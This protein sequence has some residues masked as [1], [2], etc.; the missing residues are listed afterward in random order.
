ML[1][2]PDA[3]FKMI[4]ADNCSYEVLIRERE[5]L[6]EEIRRLEGLIFEDTEKTDPA[7]KTIPSPDAAYPISLVYLEALSQ[8]MQK[9]YLE[10]KYESVGENK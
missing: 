2:D 9:R 4:D 3:Y 7:W 5:K 10:K 6:C 1:V 8:L